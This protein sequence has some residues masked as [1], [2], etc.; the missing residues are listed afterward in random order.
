MTHKDKN[1]PVNDVQTS[2]LQFDDDFERSFFQL[3]FDRNR[4]TFED[5]SGRIPEWE[6][7][8][9]AIP[10]APGRMTAS[11]NS[12]IL[13]HRDR[14]S[15]NIRRTASR[16]FD[17]PQVG[18]VGPGVQFP[19]GLGQADGPTALQLAARHAMP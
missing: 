2:G 12:I 8:N 14:T 1:I 9:P 18:N 10:R 3:Q 11:N 17:Q 4:P 13:E 16:A 19:Y 15:T 5:T 6:F 7:S